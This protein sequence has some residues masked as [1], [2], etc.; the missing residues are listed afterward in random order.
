ML[1]GIR[2]EGDMQGRGPIGSLG[3]QGILRGAGVLHD[4][5]YVPQGSW[6]LSWEPKEEAR[7]E[8][9]SGGL[10]ITCGREGLPWT[11]RWQ[12][13]GREGGGFES[14]FEGRIDKMGKA[15]RTVSCPVRVWLVR[16][17]QNGD[18][19]SR[20]SQGLKLGFGH[21]ES[22]VSVGH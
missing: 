19:E 16:K 12:T 13:A 17:I 7:E 2:V 11:K 14:E 8:G 18:P 5:V 20:R 6:W 21:T 1:E 15:S 3:T 4:Q 22:E 9:K 10:N